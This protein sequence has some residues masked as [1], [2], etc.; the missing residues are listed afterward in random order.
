[1][2]NYFRFNFKFFK[3]S[4]KLCFFLFC[5]HAEELSKSSRVIWYLREF[6]RKESDFNSTESVE[7]RGGNVENNINPAETET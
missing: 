1:M 7:N 4:T 5:C 2:M 6:E 3:K